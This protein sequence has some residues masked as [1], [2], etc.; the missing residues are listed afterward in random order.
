MNVVARIGLGAVGSAAAIASGLKIHNALSNRTDNELSE[1][2][3]SVK[4]SAEEWATWSA[5]VERE[6]PGRSLDTPTDH[7]RFEAFLQANPAPDWITVEHTD[8]TRIKVKTNRLPIP[9]DQV[10]IEHQKSFMYPAAGG[11][12]FAAGGLAA[13]GHGLLKGGAGSTPGNVAKLLAGPIAAGIGVSMLSSGI[14][15]LVKGDG[16]D[17]VWALQ[18]EVNNS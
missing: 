7:A 16:L 5:K 18:K 9:N 17:P 6:F 8:F 13:M 11:L 12:M 14:Y 3:A 2:D 1:I 10:P 4:R 15:G